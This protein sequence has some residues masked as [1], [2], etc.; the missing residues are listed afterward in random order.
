MTIRQSISFT[1]PNADWLKSQ[2]NSEEY[3][4]KSEVVNDLVR[5]AREKESE[6]EAIRA[7]LIQAENSGFTNMT[8]EEIRAEAQNLSRSNVR[9]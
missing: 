6:I 7:K 3:S 2:V 1:A 9:V 8:A 4:S 5:R